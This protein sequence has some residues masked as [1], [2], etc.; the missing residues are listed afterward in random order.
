MNEQD[1]P[2]SGIASAVLDT[3][4]VL[5][6]LVFDD[7]AARPLRAAVTAGRLCW[8]G[9]ARMHDELLGVLRRP[10]MGRWAVEP[11]APA[12]QAFAAAHMRLQPPAAAGTA[13]RCRDAAD[14]IF[15]DLAWAASAKWL[16][17]RDKALLALARTSRARGLVVCT[18][19]AWAA[20]TLAAAG[21]AGA[22]PLAPA[23]MRPFIA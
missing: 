4:T 2:D 8:L 17:T 19:A 3:N 21:P 12:V 13:P 7:P 9:T 14:Q 1:G 23:D 16:L 11:M 10:H 6:M 20:L 15:I 22:T 18:P 5:D